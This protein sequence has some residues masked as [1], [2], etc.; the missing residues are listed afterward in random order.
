MSTDPKGYHHMAYDASELKAGAR[1][2]ANGGT[3]SDSFLQQAIN[4]AAQQMGSL[5]SELREI[6]GK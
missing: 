4:N 6:L 1:I 3:L 2:L 5:G